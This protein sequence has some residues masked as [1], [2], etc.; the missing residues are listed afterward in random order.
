MLEEKGRRRSCGD[1]II[2][3]VMMEI[4]DAR[5]SMIVEQIIVVV[6][7]GPSRSENNDQVVAEG[8]KTTEVVSNTKD[9][10][11]DSKVSAEANLEIEVVEIGPGKTINIGRDVSPKLYSFYIVGQV[12]RPCSDTTL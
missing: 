4:E 3:V 12:P 10:A 7:Q 11:A 2:V 8:V 1:Q 5:E 9:A 6:Y